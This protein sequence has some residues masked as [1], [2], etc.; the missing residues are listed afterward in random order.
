MILNILFAFVFTYPVMI[1][2]SGG[3]ENS[4]VVAE[5]DSIKITAEEFYLNY[6]YGPAFPKRKKDSKKRYLDYM[7]NEKLLALDGYSR[8]ID[9]SDEAEAILNEFINDLAAEELFN[10]DI[11]RRINFDQKEIDAAISK[12][13][14]TLEIKW[15]YAESSDKIKSFLNQIGSGIS[16]DSLFSLQFNDTIFYEDRF[17]MTDR[18]SLERKNPELAAVIDSLLPGEVSLPIHAGDGWYLIK[19]ENTVQNMIS[20]ESNYE[21]ARQEAVNS[22]KKDKMDKLS[23]QYVHELIIEHEPVIKGDAF[24]FLRSYLGNYLL[25]KEKYKEWNLHEKLNSAVKNLNLSEQKEYADAVLVKFKNG[26]F[27][28]ADFITWYRNRSLYI[29]PNEDNLA[30]FSVSLEKLIWRMARDRFLGSKA[31]ERGFDKSETVLK[32]TKWWKDKIISSIVINEIRNSVLM[33]N[34]EVI[35]QDSLKSAAETEEEFTAKIL[36]KILSL[37]KIYKTRIN[38]ELLAGIQVSIENDPRAVEFYIV[39]EGTLIP[40][41]PY[42]TINHDWVKWE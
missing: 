16:F 28:V 36:R 30:N 1:S 11:L 12:K 37:R 31:R 32:Q 10:E 8:K 23:D 7:I 26:S 35:V 6:E 17:M 24:S 4:K 33:E 42:P 25:P 15:I 22:L 2:D 34:K 5:V 41:T 40:R 27:S 20:T 14:I 21:K 29:D 18:Y 39:K 13:N 3:N 19:F 38:D 9:S